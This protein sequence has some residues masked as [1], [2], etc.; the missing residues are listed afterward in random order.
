MKKSVYIKTEP[1]G[2]VVFGALNQEQIADLQLSVKNRQIEPSLLRLHFNR[3]DRFFEA[4]GV[5]NIGQNGDPGNIGVIHLLRP[6]VS[7]VGERALAW[8]D[9]VYFAYLALSKVSTEFDLDVSAD[10]FN[11][12]E[13]VELSVPIRLP[14]CVEHPTYGCP[15][16]NIVTGYAYR[17]TTVVSYDGTLIDRGYDVYWNFFRILNGKATSL[18]KNEGGQ[19]FW[20]PADE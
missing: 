6:T 4:D 10:D 15:D 19:Q 20:G 14:E 5:T 18:Y 8:A 12:K 2:R 1:G 17:G 16:F 9:G 13:F 7:Y 11:A 3:Y